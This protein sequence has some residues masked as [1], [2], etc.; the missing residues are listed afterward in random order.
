MLF[1]KRRNYFTMVFKLHVQLDVSLMDV[2]MKINETLGS[3]VKYFELRPLYGTDD[4]INFDNMDSKYYNRITVY[5]Y[6]AS[7]KVY[8]GIYRFLNNI[9]GIKYVD[10]NIYKN[11]E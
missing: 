1:N 10:S 11:S 8:D 9:P 7:N 4:L 3:M 5:C 2:E 6:D